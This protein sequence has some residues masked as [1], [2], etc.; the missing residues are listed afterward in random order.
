MRVVV[1]GAKGFIGAYLVK[2]LNDSGADVMPVSRD[3]I[4]T[5][6]GT[7]D[8]LSVIKGADAVVHLAGK[9]HVPHPWLDENDKMMDSQVTRKLAED[10]VKA[11]VPLL[12]YL[13]SVK[14]IGEGAALPYTERTPLRPEDEYGRRKRDIESMLESFANDGGINVT[15]LRPPLVY[16]IGAKANVGRLIQAIERNSWLPFKRCRAKRSYVYVKNLCDAILRVCR[17]SPVGLH[18]Y[19]ISDGSDMN[20]VEFLSVLGQG[21]G[22]QVRLVPVPPFLLRFMLSAVGKVLLYRKLN[23]SL[24]V[25]S[26]LFRKEMGWLAPYSPEKAARDMF[27]IRCQGKD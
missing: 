25:D 5:L 23:G 22:L 2:Y 4:G 12:V 7:T 20:L 21:L 10:C 11:G 9:A 26:S 14:A 18:T 27:E 24:T 15:V 16:G 1:T 6:T 17:K 3:N 8:W 19:L 13:S